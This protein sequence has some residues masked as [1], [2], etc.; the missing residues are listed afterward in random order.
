MDS[1][2][3]DC[4]WLGGKEDSGL[5][6]SSRHGTCNYAAGLQLRWKGVVGGGIA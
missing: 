1:T 3:L 4:G 2:F 6:G 5:L